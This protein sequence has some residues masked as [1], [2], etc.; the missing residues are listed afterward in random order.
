MGRI[1]QLSKNKKGI[2]KKPSIKTV[3]YDVLKNK[4][5]ISACS[6][7]VPGS[8]PRGLLRIAL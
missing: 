8:C 7:Y 6:D 1:K 4:I 3:E 2:W 5:L